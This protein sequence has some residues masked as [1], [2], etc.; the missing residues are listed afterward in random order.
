MHGTFTKAV[1]QSYLLVA[2]A[3]GLVASL[4]LAFQLRFDFNVPS[5][6]FAHAD[7]IFLGLIGAKLLLL[8]AFGQFGSL[9]SYFGFHDLGKILAV[10]LIA[11]ALALGV[12][13]GFGVLYAPPRAVIVTDC[14][15]SFLFL[16]GFRLSLRLVREGYFGQSGVDSARK[17]I[18]IIGAGDVGA[19]LVRDF[20]VR[21]G[22]GMNPV[23]FLTTIRRNGTR[24][25]TV[26]MYKARPT[27]CPTT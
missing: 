15:I 3:A 7:W 13:F 10:C 1:R 4:W 11:A 25:F 12:W 14:L 5:E 18:A 2:Y 26:S 17:R 9:L 6:Y 27:A 8:V 16:C 23:A 20:Q 19:S 22:L 21:R 24:A